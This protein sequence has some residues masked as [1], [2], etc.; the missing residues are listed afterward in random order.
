MALQGHQV[1]A[2]DELRHVKVGDPHPRANAWKMEI[3]R[4]RVRIE[5]VANI[6]GTK[7][8]IFCRNYLLWQK[9]MAY[10]LVVILG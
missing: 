10:A 1:L 6:L 5:V 2:V 4:L 7:P 8:Q 3:D 9:S